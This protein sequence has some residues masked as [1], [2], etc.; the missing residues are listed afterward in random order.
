ME[1]QTGDY[2]ANPKEVAEKAIR[3]FAIHDN[4]RDPAAITLQSSFE[5][6]GLNSL[7]LAEIFLAAEREFHIEIADEDCESFS[8]VNDFVEHVARNFYTR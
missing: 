8:T 4:V 1:M 7:D 5:D 6:L 3:L 2:Y